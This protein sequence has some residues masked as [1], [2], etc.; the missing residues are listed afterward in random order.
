MGALEGG[1]FKSV[2]R[3]H[4]SGCSWIKQPREGECEITQTEKWGKNRKATH[5]GTSRGLGGKDGGG[6]EERQRSQ[7]S[8][9]HLFRFMNF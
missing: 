9:T 5:E 4:L 8:P 6:E 3:Q 1:R 2:Q 7:N